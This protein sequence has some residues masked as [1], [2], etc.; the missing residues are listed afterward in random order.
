MLNWV[1]FGFP[2]LWALP[3]SPPP[4]FFKDNNPDAYAASDFVNTQIRDLLR[5]DAIAVSPGQP[6]CVHPLNVVSRAN[7]KQRLILD[8]RHVNQFLHIPKFRLDSLQLLSDIAD[9][10]DL[11]FS[12]DLASGYHQVLMAPSAF[13]YL[14]FCW[15]GVFYVYKVLPFG[16]ATAPWC[17]SK[18]MRVICTYLRW[19]NNQQACG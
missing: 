3:S 9:L 17:F 4:P 12:L 8:L 1:K 19:C 5:A 16:L 18:I 7:G 6:I 13:P 2:L 15:D 11:M 10:D 14:G